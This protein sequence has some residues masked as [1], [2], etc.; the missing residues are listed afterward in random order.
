MPLQVRGAAH[1]LAVPLR[2]RTSSGLLCGGRRDAVMADAL[3]EVFDLR[4]ELLTVAGQGF[5]FGH[6]LA[7]GGG[8]FGCPALEGSFALLH[9]DAAPVQLLMVSNA[10]GGAVFDFESPLCN[11][12]RT[13]LQ[14]SQGLFKG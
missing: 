14:I 13:G 3:G 2:V 5:E 11:F 1:L 10:F 7:L 6:D 8:E 12:G 9:L 4:I